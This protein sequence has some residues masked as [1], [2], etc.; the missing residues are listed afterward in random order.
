MQL[1]LLKQFSLHDAEFVHVVDFLDAG[2]DADFTYGDAFDFD[3][4]SSGS[5]EY[6]NV[7]CE[8]SVEH[9]RRR[10]RKKRGTNRVFCRENIKKSCWYRYF[11][12]PGLTREITHE[13]SSS[14]RYGEFR[15]WFRMPL[16]K[17]EELTNILIDREYINT[18][19]SHRRRVVFRERS[20]LLVMSALYLLGTGA[21]FHSCKPLCGISTSEVQK[22]FYMFI[23]A[24][25]DMKDEYIYLPRNFA[26]LKS[27]IRDYNA[28]GLPG[29]VGSMDVVHVKWSNCPSGDHN[30]A[31]GKEGYPT[32]GFQCITDFNWRVMAIYGPQF[33]SQ[34]D[35]DIVKH[36]VNVCAIRKKHLFTNTTWQIM[37]EMGTFNQRAVCT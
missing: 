15:H 11:T 21:A 34:N 32:L 31:K 3:S 9:R 2:F 8:Y 17:V 23:E 33:G 22:F 28:A 12:R 25:V 1:S 5:F 10:S 27:V 19:R 30:R 37:M 14:D 29:C 35:K 20:E 18:P 4:I 16:T 24:L 36:D 13:L 6:D 26:E 7:S